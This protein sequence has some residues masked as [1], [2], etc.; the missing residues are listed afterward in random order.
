[1]A[2]MELKIAARE[3][4]RR[5]ASIKLTIAPDEIRYVPTVIS[6]AIAKLPVTLTRRAD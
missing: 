1:M 3:V 5:I 4:V 2:R 6:H